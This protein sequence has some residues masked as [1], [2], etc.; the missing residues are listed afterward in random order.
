MS[1]SRSHPAHFLHLTIF[2]RVLTIIWPE[3][4]M[5][6]GQKFSQRVNCKKYQSRFGPAAP[7]S[8]EIPTAL[9]KRVLTLT[10]RD[11]PI[12]TEIRFRWGQ[13]CS[14]STRWT[15][16][17]YK[18]TTYQSWY[19]HNQLSSCFPSP[20]SQWQCSKIDDNFLILEFCCWYAQCEGRQ[21]LAYTFQ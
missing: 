8:G 2:C 13:L 1:F 11:Y 10:T 20:S 14:S 15:T 18:F 12:L 17:L 16:Q 7:F 3:K 19:H 9:Q 4:I 5:K 21:W 6:A